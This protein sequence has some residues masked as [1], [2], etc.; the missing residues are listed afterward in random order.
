MTANFS[1]IPRLLKI[2]TRLLWGWERFFDEHGDLLRASQRYYGNAN[3]RRSEWTLF[4]LFGDYAIYNLLVSNG[5]F[6]L[7]K[8][9]LSISESLTR[10]LLWWLIGLADLDLIFDSG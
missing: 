6:I 5:K 9:N 1:R 3:Q 10:Y 7:I 4:N 8:F 2:V